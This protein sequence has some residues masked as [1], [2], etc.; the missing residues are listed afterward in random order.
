MAF[1]KQKSRDIRVIPIELIY[2]MFSVQWFV[3][4]SPYAIHIYDYLIPYSY[5]QC[6]TS[7]T[8]IRVSTRTI[9]GSNNSLSSGRRQAIIWTNAGIL[10]IGPWGKNYSEISIKIDMVSSKRKCSHFVTASLSLKRIDRFH[11]FNRAKT[12]VILDRMTA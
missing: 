10:L 7:V 1:R 2:Q 4:A 9:I 3:T 5:L 8:H 12:I 11:R 6:H